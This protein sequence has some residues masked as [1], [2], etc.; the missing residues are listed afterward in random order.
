M[1]LNHDNVTAAIQVTGLSLGCFNPATKNWEVAFIN[2]PTHMVAVRINELTAA[3]SKPLPNIPRVI[4]PGS[5]ITVTANN[6]V[7]PDTP[8]YF[9]PHDPE[10]FDLILDIEKE[11]YN[12][13]V[14][15]KAVPDFPV[16]GMFVSN[17]KLYSVVSQKSKEEVKLVAFG[18]QTGTAVKRFGIIATA[19]GADITC[20]D[21]GSVIFEVDGQGW[22]GVSPVVLP[23][24]PS[25]KYIIELDNTCPPDFTRFNTRAADAPLDFVPGASKLSRTGVRVL[26]HS[27]FVLYYSLLDPPQGVR[28][29][30]QEDVPPAHGFGAVCNYSHL[31]LTTSLF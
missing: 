1:P 20:A 12:Q 22:Q 6:P 14:P 19:A 27:D 8:F 3:G 23:H 13:L 7:L 15:R 30:L 2:E 10:D 29:D 18:D 21:G 26:P 4:M 11:V 16:T 24:E 5:R 31:G 17:A 25:T 9:A 28:F